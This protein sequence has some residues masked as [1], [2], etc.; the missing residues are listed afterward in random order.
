MPP[1]KRNSSSML[2]SESF[3]GNENVVAEEVDEGAH[4]IAT[5][6]CLTHIRPI[7]VKTIGFDA[8]SI[9][10]RIHL[11]ILLDNPK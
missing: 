5:M 1:L 2:P 4:V 8:K 7:M 3:E 11:F 9:I 6:I 10:S